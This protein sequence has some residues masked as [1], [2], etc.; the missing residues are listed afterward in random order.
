MKMRNL[1]TGMLAAGLAYGASNAKAG[2]VELAVSQAAN[3]VAEIEVDGAS[4]HGPYDEVRTD[5]LT[6]IAAVRG[7]WNYQGTGH[8]PFFLWISSHVQ[9]YTVSDDLVPSWKNYAVSRPYIDPMSPNVVNARIS[10]IDLCNAR[11][12]QTAGQ[13]REQF[14]KQGVVFTQPN[15]YE[16]GGNAYVLAADAFNANTE[17]FTTLKVPAKIVCMPLDRPRPH[18]DTSTTGAPGPTGKP[19]PPTISKA[20]FHIEPAEIV[21]DGKFLCPSQL[22]LYGYVEAIRKFYG[23]ALFVGPHYLSAITTLNFQA[24]GSRNV[25]GTYKMDWHPMGGLATAPNAEPKKQ[26]LTFHFNIANKDGKLLKS[27]EETVEV[28]CKKIK[29]NVPIVG[30]EMT[31]KPAN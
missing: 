26:K 20:T 10:P 31:V 3:S 16:L 29:V 9:G 27:V 18:T 17:N 2:Q 22:K 8:P 13:A 4:N 11:L 15:A 28:S 7:A 25:V 14:L 21:Q 23:N 24:E 30:D 6:Y 5:K 12:Q 19:L 1:M